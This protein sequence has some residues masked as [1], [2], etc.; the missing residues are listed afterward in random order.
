MT[1]LNSARSNQQ[2]AADLSG[3]I[4]SMEELH[5]IPEINTWVEKDQ[6][7]ARV[8][9][10]FGDIVATYVAPCDG[11]VVG[12]NVDP[13]CST[14]DRILHLGV[15]EDTFPVHVDDGHV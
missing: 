3:C 9:N 12:K 11:I 13:V 14:G 6:V 5:V 15:V 4:V 2:F 8:R 7:I 1:H 10:V